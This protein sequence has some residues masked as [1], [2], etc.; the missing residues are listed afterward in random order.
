MSKLSDVIP[1][2]F[3]T[4]GPSRKLSY[5]AVLNA[6]F[7]G[8]MHGAYRFEFIRI[9]QLIVMA[10][11]EPRDLTNLAP[12]NSS[13]NLLLELALVH[14][15]C[16]LHRFVLCNGFD[17]QNPSSCSRARLFRGRAWSNPVND[18]Y[19][20]PGKGRVIPFTRSKTP[21]ACLLYI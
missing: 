8:L 4:I 1:D 21:C 14:Y 20:H 11:P 5:I 10:L 6:N 12:T 16:V 15:N 3:K 19:Q 2:E 13:T 9:C 7:W 18:T 17:V